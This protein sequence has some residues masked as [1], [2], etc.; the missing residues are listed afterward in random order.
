MLRSIAAV[1]A[2]LAVMIVLV[3]VFGV[4]AAAVIFPGDAD[5]APADPTTAWLVV[6]MAYSFAAALAGGW[7]TARIAIRKKMGHA[8]ALALVVFLLAVPGIVTGPAAGQPAW[9]AIVIAGIGVLGVLTGGRLGSRE[10][11]AVLA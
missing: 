7:V 11:T 8:A 10:A 6:N 3:V 9:Y 4:I 1:I 5:R 2:G